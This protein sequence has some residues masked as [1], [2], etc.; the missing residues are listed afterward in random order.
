[1]ADL[2]RHDRESLFD[3]LF[4]VLSCFYRVT[5][6]IITALISGT[7]LLIILNTTNITI[8]VSDI[9]AYC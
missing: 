2:I 7:F 5:C 8:T 4:V 3:N 1:M 9:S 6:S